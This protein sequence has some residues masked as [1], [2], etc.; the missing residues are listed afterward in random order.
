MY[1]IPDTVIVI[2]LHCPPFCLCCPLSVFSGVMIPEPQRLQT[3]MSLYSDSLCAM[4][5]LVDNRLNTFTGI[6]RGN[7]IHLTKLLPSV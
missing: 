2:C 5:L 4:I 6:K 1:H 7:Y 3:A